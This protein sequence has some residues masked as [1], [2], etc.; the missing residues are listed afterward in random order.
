MTPLA[1]VTALLR[2]VTGGDDAAAISADS[3]LDG[4]LRLDSIELM[5]LSTALRERHGA[6]VDLFAFVAGLELD[7]IIDLTVG[8]VAAY[9]AGHR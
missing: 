5:A 4:D 9:V 6:D 1:E 8:D 2:D 3:R 7:Q